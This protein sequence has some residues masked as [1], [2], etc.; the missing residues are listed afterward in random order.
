MIGPKRMIHNVHITVIWRSQCHSS[1]ENMRCDLMF[2]QRRRR[3]S[4]IKPALGQCF[5]FAELP[6]MTENSLGEI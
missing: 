6:D 4:S 5:I 2:G 3:L 1:P